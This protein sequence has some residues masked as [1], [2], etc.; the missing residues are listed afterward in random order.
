MEGV[1]AG[2]AKNEGLKDLVVEGRAKSAGAVKL[3]AAEE[4]DGSVVRVDAVALNRR[5][6][7]TNLA[8]VSHCFHCANSHSVVV[9]E[10]SSVGNLGKS[11]GG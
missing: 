1:V 4:V 2:R 7:E 10:R 11:P 5:V 8:V 6:E 9:K 3:D